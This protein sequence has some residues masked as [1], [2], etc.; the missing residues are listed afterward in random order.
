MAFPAGVT[1]ATITLGTMFDFR[2]EAVDD[3]SAS[4]EVFLGGNATKLNYR[5]TGQT[6]LKSKWTE[7]TKDG[8]LSFQLPHT[9]QAGFYAGDGG[10]AKNWAYIITIT[11]IPKGA[12]DR[13]SWTKRL[14]VPT[15]QDSIDLDNVA[16]GELTAWVSAPQ[17]AVTSVNGM[18]GDVWISGGT[19]TGDG[20]TVDL[21]GYAKI[22][23]LTDYAKIA[24][25]Q[26]EMA[27]KAP[28]EHEH[29]DLA[30]K[31]ELTGGLA[32]KAAT[33]HTHPDLARAADLAGKADAVHTHS[34]LEQRLTALEARPIAGTVSLVES[35]AGS[36]LYELKVV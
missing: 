12:K 23:Q 35:P 29:P 24:D 27:T 14:Q 28:A 2:G 13:I 15:G 8:I 21:S 33:V 9:D 4:I 31:A 32:G 17:A 5:S 3:L 18:T 20:G 11:A 36:G 7:S 6:A 1:T 22:T 26:N 30:T 25:V 34:D 10:E 16:D 19:G